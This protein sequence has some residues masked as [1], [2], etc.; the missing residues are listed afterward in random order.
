M[1]DAFPTHASPVIDMRDSM[2]EAYFYDYTH[3][4]WGGRKRFSHQFAE[5]IASYLEQ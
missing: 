2:S 5:T 3:L 4:N 1:K